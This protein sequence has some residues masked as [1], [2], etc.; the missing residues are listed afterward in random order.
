MYDDPSPAALSS[1]FTRNERS[2]KRKLAILGIAFAVVTVPN[3]A[4]FAADLLR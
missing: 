2:M 1:S 3:I 4:M